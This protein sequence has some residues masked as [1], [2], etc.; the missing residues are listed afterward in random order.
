M[1]KKRRLQPEKCLP[2]LQQPEV[3]PAEQMSDHIPSA[4]DAEGEERTYQSRSVT[5]GGLEGDLGSPLMQRGELAPVTNL[6]ECVR[7][8]PSAWLVLAACLHVCAA[9]CCSDQRVTKSR[10]MVLQG[11][12]QMLRPKGG[13]STTSL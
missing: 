9:L 5:E 4:P 6:F 2:D 7:Y 11:I 13:G 10:A 12:L 8:C 3:S 1:A